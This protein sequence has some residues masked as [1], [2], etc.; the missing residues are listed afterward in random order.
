MPHDSNTSLERVKQPFAIQNIDDEH[1]AIW[2]AIS[3]LNRETTLP[4]GSVIVKRLGISR[5]KV[6]KKVS[7][8]LSCGCLETTNTR[9]QHLIALHHPKEKLKAFI[10]TYAVRESIKADG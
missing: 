2:E 8:L 1:I 5:A 6:Y 9:P 10:D 3:Q 4:R 7:E